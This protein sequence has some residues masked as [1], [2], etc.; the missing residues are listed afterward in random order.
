[1]SGSAMPARPTV[2]HRRPA[3]CRAAWHGRMRDLPEALRQRWRPATNF[4][5][6]ST[7]PLASVA[8]VPSVTQDLIGARVL[9]PPRWYVFAPD[10][11]SP[12]FSRR[13]PVAVLAAAAT[14]F[15]SGR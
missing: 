13:I 11:T 4:S 15:C 1:M 6:T 5:A 3:Q 7:P 8:E 2:A 12:N 9:L 10:E 14:E